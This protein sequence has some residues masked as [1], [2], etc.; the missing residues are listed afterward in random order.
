MN[1]T[2]EIDERTIIKMVA[3]PIEN[4]VNRIKPRTEN[5]NSIKL[6][7]AFEVEG[8]NGELMEG[9]GKLTFGACSDEVVKAMMERLGI[10]EISK[11]TPLVIYLGLKV[12]PDRQ[13]GLEDFGGN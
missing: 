3:I 7:I 12:E 1:E 10:D 2:V 11:G 9:T 5:R 4:K 8:N 13:V 6:G